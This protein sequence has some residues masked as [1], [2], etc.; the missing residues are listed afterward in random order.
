MYLALAA[1]FVS[2][3]ALVTAIAALIVAGE[4]RDEQRRDSWF[5][6]RMGGKR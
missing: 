5:Q 1:F 2:V 6:P 3:L 4:A